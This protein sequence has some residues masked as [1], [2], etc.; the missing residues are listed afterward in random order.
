[1]SR[2]DLLHDAT[3]L[4]PRLEIAVPGE[5]E[6]VVAGRRSDGR[7][8]FYFGEEPAYHFDADGRLRRAFENGEL[9]R[10][11]GTTLARLTRTREAEGTVLARHDLSAEE[12]HAFLTRMRERLARLAAADSGALCVLRAEPAEGDHIPAALGA[13]Q[14]ALAVGT[15]LAPALKR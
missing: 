12:L 8:S 2:E 1:M 10:S 14:R 3:A 13:A 11:Q 4:S 15:P 5:A 9:Y 7:W 6:P